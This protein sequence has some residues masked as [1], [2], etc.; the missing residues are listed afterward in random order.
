MDPIKF[1]EF[2]AQVEQQQ[3][4]AAGVLVGL[5]TAVGGA[6]AW[7]AI[8]V[9]TGYQIGYMAIGVGFL[10]GL[11]VR[12][13]GKGVTPRFAWAGCLLALFGCL[14]GNVLSACAFIAT[15]ESIP[16]FDVLAQITPYRAIRILMATFSPMDL[17]FYGFALYAGWQYSLRRITPEELRGMVKQNPANG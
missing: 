17:L 8:T 4:L 7:A 6:I 2:Q 15:H 1:R 12:F 11:A 14:L 13:F 3:N 16:L 10:V 5:A 9:A